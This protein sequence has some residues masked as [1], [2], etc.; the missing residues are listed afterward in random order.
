VNLEYDRARMASWIT[1][2]DPHTGCEVRVDSSDNAD[3]PMWSLR[4]RAEA[5]L[6]DKIEQEFGFRRAF[7]QTW[8]AA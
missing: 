6:A 7:R 4:V 1:L 3:E 5:A 8:E 2:R